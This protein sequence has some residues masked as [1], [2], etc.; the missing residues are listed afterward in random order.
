MKEHNLKIPIKKWVMQPQECNGTYM[1]DGFHVITRGIQNELEYEDIVW[2]FQS[3]K[4]FILKHGSAD[5]L[6][7]F[8]H[9][10]QKIFV[11][12]NL[13]I[14]MKKNQTESFI[15]KNNYFTIMFADEY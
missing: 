10:N 2:I 1:F 11:I 6:F 3:I 7:V 13:N 14:E 5:Y 15:T 12:D 8:K 4:F 9:K